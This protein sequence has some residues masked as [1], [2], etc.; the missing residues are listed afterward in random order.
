M[1]NE[2]IFEDYYDGY[3]IEDGALYLV[4]SAIGISAV[5]GNTLD[6]ETAE[7][8]FA[9]DPYRECSFD[10]VPDRIAKLFVQG[11]DGIDL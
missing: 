3:L 10:D 8:V 5:Y 6:E 2:I 9:N 7:F 4:D 1:Q 11:S